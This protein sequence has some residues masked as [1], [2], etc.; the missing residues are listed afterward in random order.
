MQ[1]KTI[2]NRLQKH[3]GFVY[4]RARL[5][6]ATGGMMSV[7]VEIRA[8][9]K[10]RPV[11][12]GCG[13]RCAGYDTLAPRWFEF[14]PLWGLKVF[15]VYARRRADC[16][17]CGLHVE[18]VPWADGNHHLTTTFSWFLARWAKHLSWK[19][20]GEA[21]QT[22]WSSVFRA[23]EMAVLWGRDHVDLNGIKALGIDEING[24]EGTIT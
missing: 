22:S 2:L 19:E 20:V 24:S 16:P 7:E 4:T 5:V 6:E 8:R 21:F 12:S 11:C 18:V 23:V 3:P 9:S 17:T 10:S 15:F 13:Q 1:V 14:V